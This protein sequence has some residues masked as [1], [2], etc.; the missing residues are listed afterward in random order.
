MRSSSMLYKSLEGV[1]RYFLTVLKYPSLTSC[2]HFSSACFSFLFLYFVVSLP[3]H[4]SPFS[5]LCCYFFFHC[6]KEFATI[7]SECWH[8]DARHR[9]SSLQLLEKLEAAIELFDQTVASSSTASVPAT[10]HT[11]T[12]TS[13]A[14]SSIQFIVTTSSQSRRFSVAGL[15]LFLFPFLLVG[16]CSSPPLRFVFLCSYTVSVEVVTTFAGHKSSPYEEE[17]AKDGKGQ[18]AAFSSPYGI[19]INPHDGCMYVCDDQD[20]SIRRVTMEGIHNKLA[21]SF[22][23][24]SF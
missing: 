22:S 4:L 2:L 7:I 19:C 13:T 17:E 16:S 8:D 18:E 6:R 12:E 21:P 15:H 20:N 3:S 14:P 5:S 1:Q 10:M 23:S 9:P 24:V 11:S